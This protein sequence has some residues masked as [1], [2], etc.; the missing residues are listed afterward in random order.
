MCVF[1][2][3]YL[4][5]RGGRKRKLVQVRDHLV[6]GMRIHLGGREVWREGGVEG[7]VEGRRCGGRCGG[8]EV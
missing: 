2:Y 4:H 3:L 8:R 7:G 1:V 6:E 5:R